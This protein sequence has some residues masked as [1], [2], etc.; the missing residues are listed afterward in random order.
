MLKALHIST[1]LVFCV[2][3]GFVFAQPVLPPCPN[4]RDPQL[5]SFM[6][7][8]LLALYDNNPGGYYYIFDDESRLDE[9][10]DVS[11]ASQ[12]VWIDTERELLEELR[13]LDNVDYK[14]ADRTD[15]DLLHYRLTMSQQQ[16]KLKAFQTPI[17]SISGPQ[18]WLPQMSSRLPMTTDIHREMYLSRL[19]QVDVL[20]GDHIENMRAGIQSVVEPELMLND[21]VEMF[22]MLEALLRLRPG[23]E[24][25]LRF[26]PG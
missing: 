25:L 21:G 4:D 2:L 13:S 12:Q 26:R 23:F 7:K 3:T 9:L 24:A 15:Y 11:A 17:T 8:Y 16:A 6:D 10:Q 14:D 1:A 22:E 5:W 20:I 19:K 18:I